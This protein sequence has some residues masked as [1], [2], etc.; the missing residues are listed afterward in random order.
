MKLRTLLL[1]TGAAFAVVGG[2][3]AADLSVA[4]PVEFVKV[5]DYF[6]TSY[7]YIPGTDTCI[8]VSGFVRFDTTFQGNTIASGNANPIWNPSLS[9]NH[10]SSW[11]FNTQA[12]IE[13]LAKSVTEYGIL[14]ADVQYDANSSGANAV[15]NLNSNTFGI[16]HATLSLGGFTAGYQGSLFNYGGDLGTGIYGGLHSTS[17]TDGVR[18]AWA[19]AGFGIAL[20]VE[21]PRDRWGSS[22]PTDIGTPD[23]IG[24]LTATQSNWDGQLA[25]AYTGANGGGWAVQAGATFKLDSIAKGDA[26]RI[27]GAFGDNAGSFVAV[28]ADPSQLGSNFS[29]LASFQHFWSPTLSSSFMGAYLNKIN[30]SGPSEWQAEADLIWSPVTNFF[31]G[32][33]IV[34]TAPST[35]SATWTIDLRLQRSW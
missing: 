5:C 28:Q 16:D 33:A 29:V 18:M 20:G 3:Q 1:G 10:S 8:R 22:Q 14:A 25:A 23:I 27:Q 31:A 17:T 2:A 21:D 24:A 34:Y 13:I 32:P 9:G 12:D 6:G 4:E 19:A 35:G 26:F 30:T 15:G 7:W 11:E